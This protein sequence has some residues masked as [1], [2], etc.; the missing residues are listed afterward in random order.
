MEQ[1]AVVLWQVV[2]LEHQ[3]EF[4]RRESQDQA[5]EATKARAAELLAV[6]RATTTE[7]GLD[8]T[9]AHEAALQKSLADTEGVLQSTLETMEMEQNTLGSEQ[10]ARSKAVQEVLALRGRV[11]GTEEASA[12]LLEWIQ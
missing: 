7:R 11:M 3:L 6:E 10:K 2:E 5:A 8:V 4:A 9:K 12:R 1:E